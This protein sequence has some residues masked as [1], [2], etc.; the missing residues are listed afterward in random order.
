MGIYSLRS[1]YLNELS[2]NKHMAYLDVFLISSKIA[3]ETTSL[4]FNESTNSSLSKFLSFPPSPLKDSERR[5]L[6]QYNLVHKE[7]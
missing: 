4:G 3:L 5:S 1:F 7:L 6:F 2:L